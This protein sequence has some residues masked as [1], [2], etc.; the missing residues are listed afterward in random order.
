[1]TSLIIRSIA[2]HSSADG[3]QFVNKRTRISRSDC[4]SCTPRGPRNEVA[5]ACNGRLFLSIGKWGIAVSEGEAVVSH[6]GFRPRSIS[7]SRHRPRQI[8]PEG[9]VEPNVGPSRGSASAPRP[10]RS[11]TNRV[12]TCR[13]TTRRLLP[14]QSNAQSVP[15]HRRRHLPPQDGV[16]RSRRRQKFRG[17]PYGI[18]LKG[19]LTI[20]LQNAGPPTQ[21]INADGAP[22]PL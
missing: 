5:R 6:V 14:Q 15:I 1:V 19:A 2:N 16:S 11:P 22:G 17:N 9:R 8:P 4:L 13:R 3:F 18:F 7:K 10:R 12:W 20:S 21:V